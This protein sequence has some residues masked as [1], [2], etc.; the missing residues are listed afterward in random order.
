[1]KGL[2]MKQLQP[3]PSRLKT[4]VPRRLGLT[5]KLT[6]PFVVILVAALCILASLS[7]RSTRAALL[8]SMQKRAMTVAT[9]MA[10]T[11]SEPLAMGEIDGVRHQLE[12]TRRNDSDVTY[13]IVL[14]GDATAIASTDSALNNE[15]LKRNDFERKM[16]DTQEY[17]QA[18]IP[19]QAGG[20]EAAAPIQFQGKRS[21]V[22]RVGFSIQT[23]NRLAL[24][25]TLLVATTGLLALLV[26]IFAYVLAS[27]RV[28]RPLLEIMSVAS[29]LAKGDV[30]REF[31]YEGQ[32]EIASLAQSFREVVG[33]NRAIA[34]ACQS[35]GKGDLS[36]DIA[37]RSD[38]DI[39]AQSFREVV[40]YNRTMAM[41]CESLGKGDLTV[42]IP[43][44]SEQDIIAQ[45][46]TQ[47]VRCIRNTV[48]E[49]DASAS[50]LATA[51]AKLSTTS[52]EMTVGAGETAT[53][54]IAVAAAAEEISANVQTVAG[55]AEQMT[56]SIREI[57]ANA[58]D[59][60]R[61]AGEGVNLAHAAHQKVGKLG[62]SSQEIGKV[63]KVITSIAAQTHLLA[64]NATI[65]A[66]RAGDAGKGFAVVAN[67]VKQLA[68]ET[69][70]ATED[71]SAKIGAI[72]I[73]T[74]SAIEG[75]AEIT[76]I[77]SRISDTQNAIATAVEEQTATTNEICRNVTGL[78]AGNRE[79]ARNISGVSLAARSTTE[80]A[81][82]TKKA[83]AEL[84]RLGA[85]LHGLV[86]QFHYAGDNQ[87]I[88][89]NAAPAIAALNVEAETTKHPLPHMLSGTGTRRELVAVD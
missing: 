13:A 38:Q 52:S 8:E 53:Q 23:V 86:R 28:I 65:E 18:M 20:F 74:Q 49:M 72:Q 55:G 31:T 32:D 82:Y 21:G 84:A 75:I 89:G 68:K 27:R 59:A 30:E 70:K 6:I 76:A 64:L 33:Y 5:A 39:I 54:A 15:V 3:L 25:D 47:A 42:T 48:Q 66:A 7:V 45:N 9:T 44:R 34:A 4:I 51:A 80:G 56:A 63:I 11:L 17:T 43:V 87:Q 19:G 46:F 16:A 24:R 78:A 67:E 12:A 37:P 35:L 69:A 26:G 1:M 88:R 2:L 10:A 62:E 61:V 40:G 41:A 71:I 79:I 60:A 58:H 50:S 22:L 73:T 83:A 57:A 77:I 29:H 81:E 36:V 14:N 85:G